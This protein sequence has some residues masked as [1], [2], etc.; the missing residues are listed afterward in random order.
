MRK[1]ANYD[2]CQWDPEDR[3]LRE[4]F[5]SD[6]E[7]IDEAIAGA[8]NTEKLLDITTQEEAVQVELSLEQVEWG[9]YR[10]LILYVETRGVQ[11]SGESGYYNIYVLSLIHISEP[12]RPY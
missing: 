8:N 5:N 12:T 7:K 1:T 3:I 11:A 4:D 2:L 6:N 9:K 10:D